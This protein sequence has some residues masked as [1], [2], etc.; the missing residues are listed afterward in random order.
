[1]FESLSLLSGGGNGGSGGGGEGGGVIG[2]FFSAKLWS[3]ELPFPSVVNSL[4]TGS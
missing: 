1:M 4:S 3:T 2:L